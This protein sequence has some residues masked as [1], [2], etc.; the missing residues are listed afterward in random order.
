[1][2][3]YR[4]GVVRPAAIDDNDL[5]LSAAT[6]P[7]LEVIDTPERLVL[8]IDLRPAGGPV[9]AIALDRIGLELLQAIMVGLAMTPGELVDYLIDSAE[10][11]QTREIEDVPTGGRL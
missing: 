7:V 4:S 10:G 5:E 8:R 11:W 6:W 3:L 9:C 1:M 2:I